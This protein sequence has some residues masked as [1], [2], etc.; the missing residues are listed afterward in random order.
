MR[1]VAVLHKKLI[2][3]DGKMVG[4]FSLVFVASCI[5]IWY[6]I[7]RN[8]AKSKRNI[9]IGVAAISFAVVGIIG[10]VD[11]NDTVAETTLSSSE[12]VKETESSSSAEV[13]V[14]LKLDNQEIEVDE[15]GNTVITGQTNP[16]A[17][18][19]VGMGIIGDSVEADSEGKFS[20]KHSLTGDEDEEVT[21][22]AKIDGASNSAT[23]TIKPNAEALAK[24][25]EEE[26]AAEKAAEEA[27]A[28]REKEEAEAAAAEEAEAKLPREH[29]NAKQKALDYLDYTAFSKEGL[30]DQ[31]LYEQYP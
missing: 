6:F 22:N 31:L 11:E 19:S 17:A 26:E 7:K 27:E 30:Y 25:Q 13:I 14:E 8:P 20:L 5:G 15:D 23:V 4:L 18:V 29:A 16:G 1:R 24:R 2:L 28:S 3:G 10:T 12:T 9:A 21:I